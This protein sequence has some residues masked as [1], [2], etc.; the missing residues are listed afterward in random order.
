MDVDF[1]INNLAY[2]LDQAF[3]DLVELAI[4]IDL[5][6]YVTRLR[7]V[8]VLAA[9]VEDLVVVLR[10]DFFVDEEEMDELTVLLMKPVLV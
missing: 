5:I 3:G 8:T 6:R 2:L 10:L 4:P 7:L 9:R 1:E